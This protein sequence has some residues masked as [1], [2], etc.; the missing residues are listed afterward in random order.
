[1]SIEPIVFFDLVI[2]LTILTGALV[3]LVIS[4]SRMLKKFHSLQKEEEHL[5][6]QMHK[7]SL[8]VLE[9]ARGQATKIITNAHFTADMSKVDFN[10]KLAAASISHIKDFENASSELLKIYQKELNALKENTIITVKN[11]SKDI[12][13]N[14]VEDL[15][16]FEEVLKRETFAS[17]KIVEEKIEETYKETQKEIEAYK[18]A[19]IKRVDDR[20]YKLLQTVSKLVL[21]KAI[22]LQDHEQLVI[23]ALDKAKKEG[24]L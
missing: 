21:G 12:E 8:D 9:E 6:L 1:M 24:I 15:R 10:D 5:K 20:I 3:T 22:S 19:E 2:S 7:K 17:Q 4:Y 23:E 13:T 14:T 16:D 11:I 18:A